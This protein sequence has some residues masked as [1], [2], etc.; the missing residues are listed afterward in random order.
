MEIYAL[1]RELPAWSLCKDD[2]QNRREANLFF[3]FCPLNNCKPKELLPEETQECMHRVANA[4]MA[5]RLP[6]RFPQLW[7]NFLFSQK[8]YLL[9][10]LIICSYQIIWH[11]IVRRRKGI[12]VNHPCHFFRARHADMP[13]SNQIVSIFLPGCYFLC[14][15]ARVQKRELSGQVQKRSIAPGFISTLII[16]SRRYF[17]AY[18]C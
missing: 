12:C 17:I 16:R 6:V 9:K 1:P 7:L 10:K 3:S 18:R 2:T 14:E 11:S 13:V 15:E 4:S 5:V 8:Y